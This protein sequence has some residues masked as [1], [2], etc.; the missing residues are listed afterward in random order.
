M[1]GLEL[2]ESLDRSYQV[3]FTTSAERYAVDT[4]ELSVIDYLVKHIEY[5]RFLTAALKAKENL[6]TL[7]KTSEG[8]STIF[9][10]S[11]SKLV[12]LD[13]EEINFIEALADYVIF[14][15]TKGKFIVRSTMKGIEKRLSSSELVRV[16]RSFMINTK[17]INALEDMN[18][19]MTEKSIP[20]GASYKENLYKRLNIL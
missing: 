13:I 2:I 8:Q 3:V 16:H 18:V 10:K 15:T 7:L 11:D 14:N 1:T 19:T 20:I 5:P 4:F 6:A 17:K 9:I 12:K